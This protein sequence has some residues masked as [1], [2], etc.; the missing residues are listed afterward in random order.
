MS[1][2]RAAAN[3]T[4]PFQKSEATPV[5]RTRILHHEGMQVRISHR[6]GLEFAAEA[7][8]KAVWS[9]ATKGVGGADDALMPTELLLASLGSCAGYY[10]AQY[11]RKHSL[12]AEGLA[13]RVKA[14]VLKDP[15]RLDNF[16]VD[17]E[18]PAVPQEHLD[19][20]RQEILHCTVHNT[21]THP[22]TIR[23]D[24]RLATSVESL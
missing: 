14:D 6:G 4:V 19:A 15:G 11:L 23:L 18:A 22:P 20:L 21:L 1:V 2:D 17:L 10:A 13:I 8:G 7:R 16:V 3:R 9:S 24:L 5:P 12:S